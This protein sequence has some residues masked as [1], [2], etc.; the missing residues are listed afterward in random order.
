M[1]AALQPFDPGLFKTLLNR[2]ERK[3]AAWDAKIRFN[4][5]VS[6]GIKSVGPS[7]HPKNNWIGMC[8]KKPCL[9]IW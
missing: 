7:V 6:V 1:P 2:I 8:V 5:P 9:M 3:S 4:S